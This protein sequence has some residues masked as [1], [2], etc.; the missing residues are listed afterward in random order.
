[1][2]V[3][4]GLLFWGLFLI[5]LGGISLLV[6][7]GVVDADRLSEAWRLWPLILVGIGLAIVLGRSRTAVLG[8]AVI[9]LIL[10]TLGGSALAS[11]NLWIGAFSD[12]TIAS[13]PTDQKLQQSGTLDSGAAV[14]LDL[15][16]G[17]LTVSTA[18]GTGWSLDAAYR[19]TA[20]IVDASA[21][22]LA[23]R[24]PGGGSDRRNDWT[25]GL[26]AAAVGSI[27]VSTNAAGATLV[28]PGSH[29]TRLDADVN[30]GDLRIDATQGAIDEID[31]SMNVG[32]IRL[33]VGS[34]ALDGSLSV[35]VGEIDLCVPDGVPL[36][37]DVQDQFTFVNNLASRGLARSGSI[38][39]RDAPGAARID[40]SVVGNVAS[41][42]LNP[43]GGCR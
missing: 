39:T 3:R 17:S 7:A 36:R 35:N 25:V 42:T 27:S 19:G 31:L 23:V 32:R 9:A 12:C 10:G 43:E 8:T 28:L 14:R 21:S 30:A 37:F 34:A 18:S 40:L 41:F 15:R 29:L 24:V 20:P 33:D 6:R 11:G 16:C 38:W 13:G 1:M 26:P 22:R 5:P 2:R 4:R